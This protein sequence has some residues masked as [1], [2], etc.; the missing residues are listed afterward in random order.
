MRTNNILLTIFF[1]SII[2]I[3]C[4]SIPEVQPLRYT[5]SNIENLTMYTRTLVE[6]EYMGI[7][8]DHTKRIN[9]TVSTTVDTIAH[10][11]MVVV[12]DTV[13][14]KDLY[15]IATL[16]RGCVA[17]PVDDSPKFGSMGDFSIPRKYL[18]KSLDGEPIEWTV[19]VSK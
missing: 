14:L 7:N 4:E 18:I 3:G 10:K 16:S 17:T 11:V 5:K 2:F 12:V 6:E 15:S 13:N 9:V 19:T 8:Y 1:I